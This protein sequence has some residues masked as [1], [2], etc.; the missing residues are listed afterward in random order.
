M[1]GQGGRPYGRGT[2]PI[3]R[4]DLMQQ[5]VILRRGAWNSGSQLEAAPRRSMKVADEVM[6][7]DVRWIRSYVLDEANDAAGTV[8][9]Y[10][11]R[12]PEAI[13]RHASLAGLP[14]DEIVPIA[15]TVVVHSESQRVTL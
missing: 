15:D 9:V 6:P 1:C 14:A 4:S 2:D 7:D 8:C 11:A 12:S 13:R 5:Y 3:A 10:E